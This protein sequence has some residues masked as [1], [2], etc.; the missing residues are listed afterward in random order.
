MMSLEGCE[1]VGWAMQDLSKQE[2]NASTSKTDGHR[3]C[4][5]RE[6]WWAHESSAE[7]RH[8]RESAQDV[9]RF[10]YETTKMPVNSHHE[11]G[12]M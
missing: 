3:C 2:D 11:V 12:L 5:I 6:Q 7:S 10:S 4:D 9:T 1:V 8:R